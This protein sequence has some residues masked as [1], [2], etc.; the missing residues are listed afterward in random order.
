M[1]NIFQKM[2]AIFETLCYNSTPNGGGIVMFRDKEKEK[3]CKVFINKM[4]LL[5]ILESE[6]F[7]AKWSAA[8]K[9]IAQIKE[10]W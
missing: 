8:K 1:Q 9:V 3:A 4:R 5:G 10:L 7:S 6:K 2:L